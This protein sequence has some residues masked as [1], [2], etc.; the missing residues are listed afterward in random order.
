ML[1]SQVGIFAMPNGQLM[2]IPVPARR[3]RSKRSGML[4]L[5]NHLTFLHLIISQTGQGYCIQLSLCLA[6]LF[7]QLRAEYILHLAKI[8]MLQSCFAINKI[9]RNGGLESKRYASI[10]F[11][12]CLKGQSHEKSWR[13]E[14]M[15][16]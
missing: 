12:Y 4:P 2:R 1:Q 5:S 9:V 16:I 3:V 11:T 15:G 8:A 10:S 7:N 13:D 14:G 6:K